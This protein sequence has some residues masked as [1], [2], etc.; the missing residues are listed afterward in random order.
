[1]SVFIDQLM[2]LPVV[3]QERSPDIESPA[4]S[5][6]RLAAPVTLPVRLPVTLP[7]NEL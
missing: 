2:P 1:M 3:V 6:L 5:K 7:N 4:F